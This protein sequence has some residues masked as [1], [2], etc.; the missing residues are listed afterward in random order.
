MNIK[1]IPTT[2]NVFPFLIIG[3]FITA[4]SF[5]ASV[6]IIYQ[7]NPSREIDDVPPV[8]NS[9]EFIRKEPLAVSAP[10]YVLDTTSDKDDDD[11]CNIRKFREKSGLFAIITGIEHSG[12]TITSSLVMNA[13]NLYGAFESGMLLFEPSRES[14]NNTEPMFYK[15]FSASVSRHFWGLSEIHREEL[16]V[17]ARCPAEQYNLLRRNSPIYN[18]HNTSWIVDKTPAYYHKLFSIMQRTPGV[19]VVVTQKEDESV[20]RSLKK[21]GAKEFDIKRRLANFHREIKLCKSNFPEHIYVLNHTTFTT[22][23]NKIMTELFAFLGLIWDPSY[24]TNEALN[25]KGKLIGR[26]PIPGF[27]QERSSCLD[28]NKSQPYAIPKK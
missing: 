11:V 9:N 28:C 15:G 12:T 21:R 8:Y 23:P 14:I 22:H 18:V 17:K 2:M 4:L 19:P 7:C 27:D 6:R 10:P 13:P 24:L 3:I 20:I 26:P 1:T 5:M 16:F 25:Q